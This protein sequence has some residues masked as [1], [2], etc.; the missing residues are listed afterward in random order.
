VRRRFARL[1]GD[2]RNAPAEPVR[3]M[4]RLPCCRLTLLAVALTLMPIGEPSAQSTPPSPSSPVRLLPKPVPD[5]R[6]M[7][8]LKYARGIQSIF[9]TLQQISSRLTPLP[10]YGSLTGEITSFRT[11]V[12][13]FRATYIGFV[14][15]AK[16][17][18]FPYA[19][20]LATDLMFVGADAWEREILAAQDLERATGTLQ[21]LRVRIER[22]SAARQ[23]ITYW[24]GAQQWIQYATSLQPHALE[25]LQQA[26]LK[27]VAEAA[28]EKQRRE[29]EKALILAAKAGRYAEIESLGATLASPDGRG[30]GGETALHWAAAYGHRPIVQLLISK[31]ADVNAKDGVGSTPLH[32]AAEERQTATVQF[33]LVAGSDVQAENDNGMVP[34]HLAAA[35]GDKA[36]VDL[37]LAY[38]SNVSAQDESGSTPLHLAAALGRKDVVVALLGAA[39]DREAQDADG[40]TPLDVARVNDHPEVVAAIES[41][42][43]TK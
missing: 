19:V 40:K 43:A 27:R 35:S 13:S 30:E 24:N 28:A 23:R 31:G 22:D 29:A 21:P 16:T 7:F 3:R 34:L 32:Y 12:Q 41:F 37:L 36:T 18:S 9:A 14:N 33:V 38:H 2:W 25:E 15:A 39:A 20:F 8:A 1:C 17:N 42:V 11:Q 4:V 6:T 10:Q 26:E 5:D